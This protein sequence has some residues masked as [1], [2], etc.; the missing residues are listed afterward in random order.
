MVSLWMLPLVS[1]EAKFSWTYVHYWNQDVMGYTVNIRSL[2]KIGLQRSRSSLDA[3]ILDTCLCSS[4]NTWL[5]PDARPKSIHRSG[6]SGKEPDKLFKG[7]LLLRKFSAFSARKW[8]WIV[9]CTLH[10]CG[11]PRTAVCQRQIRVA[12]PWLSPRLGCGS[13]YERV[14]HCLIAIILDEL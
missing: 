13:D 9:F 6:G 3:N 7:S 5:Y 1:N 12:F 4:F 11:P 2:Q 8:L 10:Q 14:F